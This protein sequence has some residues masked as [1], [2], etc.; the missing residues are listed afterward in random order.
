MVVTAKSDAA[1]EAGIG[2]MPSSLY[3]NRLV[4][5]APSSPL[6]PGT[7]MEVRVAATGKDITTLSELKVRRNR[8]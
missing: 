7:H 4:S 1:C 8:A 5:Y 2:F 6:L 3:T